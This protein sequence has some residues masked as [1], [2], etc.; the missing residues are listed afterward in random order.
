[1]PSITG[2]LVPTFTVRDLSRSAAWY[3]EVLE[4]FWRAPGEPDCS[5][6]S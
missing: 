3:A 1:M 6:G 2:S 4:F 5:A